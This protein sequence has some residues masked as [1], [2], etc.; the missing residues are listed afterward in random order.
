MRRKFAFVSQWCRPTQQSQA[1]RDDFPGLLLLLL[2]QLL[3]FRQ[4]AGCI[5]QSWIAM[6]ALQLRHSFTRPFGRELQEGTA[7]G[8]RCRNGVEVGQTCHNPLCYLRSLWVQLVNLTCGW[9]W[10][11]GLRSHQFDRLDGVGYTG[12][13]LRQ[14]YNLE[15]T[16]W[17][18]QEH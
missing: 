13:C 9:S 15:F 6:H 7:G 3:L 10:L 17:R 12:I 5:V 16:A 2:L 4:H 11:T 1:Y 14:S 18:P 8:R